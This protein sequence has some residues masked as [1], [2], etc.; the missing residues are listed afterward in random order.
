[1]AEF[2]GEYVVVEFASSF[3]PQVVVAA[4]KRLAEFGVALPKTP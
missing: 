4:R 3:E 2:T 1:M